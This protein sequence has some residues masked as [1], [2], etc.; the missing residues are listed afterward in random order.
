MPP[1][2][3]S[4]RLKKIF[5]TGKPAISNLFV[6]PVADRRLVAVAVPVTLQGT[7]AF[8]VGMAIRPEHFLRILKPE[9]LPSGWVLTILDSKG[10][11]VSRTHSPEQFVGKPA[12]PQLLRRM[13]EGREDV[14]DI[15][16]LEGTP[17]FAAFSRSAFSGWTVA[18]GVPR[19][20]LTAHLRPSI[21]LSIVIAATVLTLAALAANALSQRIS[22]SIRGLRAPALA[23]AS[24]GPLSIE[25]SDTEEVAEVG[26]A[27]VAASRLLAQRAQ[28]RAKAQAAEQQA[29][30][31]E[32]TATRFRAF[33]DASPNAIVVTR[34][35]GSITFANERASTAFGYATSDL[36]GQSIERLIPERLWPGHSAHLKGFFGS[37]VAPPHDEHSTGTALALFARRKDGSEFP[38]EFSLSPIELEGVPK[39]MAVIRDLTEQK[40]L[41]AFVE[42]SRSQM[43]SSARLSALGTMAGGVAHEVNNPL[44]VIHALASDLADEG[45]SERVKKDAERIV[46]YADRIDG[47]VK[48]LLYLARDG[49]DDPFTAASVAAIVG[50]ALDL[51]SERFR[52]H[53]VTL[54]TSPIDPGLRIECREVQISQIVSNLLQNAFDAVQGK[55]GDKWVRL[56][57]TAEAGQ[58]MLSVVDSGDGVPTE[59]KARIMEPFFTTKPVG[60]GTGLGL[61]LSRRIAEDH[62]GTLTLGERDGHTCFTLDLPASR[63]GTTPCN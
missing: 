23:L 21:W 52:Q 14:I 24:G 15:E 29:A 25:P 9:Q 61:S 22:R 30:V 17:V 39:V 32:R 51:L 50:R 12:A 18:I 63:Q 53:S 16:T 45:G 36:L 34:S 47:I 10:T 59:A 57:V 62:G 26:E 40:R 31:A 44:A 4:E 37:P 8:S 1:I 54:T 49:T 33:L 2:A 7:V 38:A 46:Q 27:L 19:A 20:S 13:A 60:K 48:S 3:A 58:V 43:I 6:G 56:E 55:S 42:T 11:I 28:D 35:D 5:V 41:E